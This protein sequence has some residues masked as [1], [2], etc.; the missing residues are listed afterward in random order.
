MGR[1]RQGDTWMAPGYKQAEV[2]PTLGLSR[3]DARPMLRCKG[4]PTPGVGDALET[5]PLSQGVEHPVVA[6][7]KIVPNRRCSNRRRPGRG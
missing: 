3:S 2:F 1:S 7:C 4:P 6:S 5:D